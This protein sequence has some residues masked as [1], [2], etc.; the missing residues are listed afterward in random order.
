[1]SSASALLN[2]GVF[3][4]SIGAYFFF[5]KP[6]ATLE[7]FR[8]AESQ[9]AYTTKSMMAA[10][11]LLLA[12]I[13]LQFTA[14][15]QAV[16]S[17][18]GGKGTTAESV[19][20]AFVYTLFPWLFIFGALI[21]ALFVF[22]GFK[23]AFADVVGYF[24]ISGAANTLLAELLGDTETHRKLNEIQN[25]TEEQRQQMAQLQTTADE[26]MKIQGNWAMLVNQIVP[27]NFESFWTLLTPLKKAAHR[28]DTAESTAALKRQ[29]FDLV[30]SRDNVGEAMWYMYAGILLT[31]VVQLKI[32]SEGCGT[33]S[34]EEMEANYQKFV[35]Q[36]KANKEA[37]EKA[38]THYTLSS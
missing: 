6:R 10:G 24:Y 7:S 3:A 28:D 26:V 25:P 4:A 27:R 13:L 9:S 29:L 33:T 14:N 34:P 32:M 37:K 17:L 23:C 16:S 1:M 2:L 11:L 31:S 19:R 12:T 36:E 22:P 35:A 5:F 18:C 21:L 38:A 30:V 15:I 20:T 8:D